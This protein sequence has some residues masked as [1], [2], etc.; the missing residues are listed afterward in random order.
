MNRGDSGGPVFDQYGAIVGIASAGYEQQQLRTLVIPETLT[1]RLRQAIGILITSQCVAPPPPDRVRVLVG[2][3]DG[4]DREFWAKPG[5]GDDESFQDC[6]P[7]CPEM[8]V[9]PAGSF[10]MGAKLPEKPM[11]LRPNCPDT[12]S[13][14]AAR[15]RLAN[16]RSRMISGTIARETWLACRPTANPTGDAKACPS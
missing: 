1:R 10:K 5:K 14:S 8:A 7:G 11:L 9:I 6:K 13:A 3:G 16:S 12:M 2:M 4:R 15:W